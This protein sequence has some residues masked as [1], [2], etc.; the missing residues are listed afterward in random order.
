ML[1]VGITALLTGAVFGAAAHA[2]TAYEKGLCAAAD[3]AGPGSMCGLG[4]IIWGP[5]VVV[6]AVRR[7]SS[8]SR[9]APSRRS[10]RHRF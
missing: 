9:S 3:A 6:G 4:V 7:P 10:T 1:T 8:S 2:V 5:A